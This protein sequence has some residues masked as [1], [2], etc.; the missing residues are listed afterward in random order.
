MKKKWF[1]AALAGTLLAVLLLNGCASAQTAKRQVADTGHRRQHKR[2]N[3]FDIAD[4]HKAPP[5][6]IRAK[7]TE[8]TKRSRSPCHKKAARTNG[9][10]GRV[11]LFILPAG[12]AHIRDAS[13]PT[14]GTVPQRQSCRIPDT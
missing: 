13:L 5:H 4:L 14:S 8:V 2:I 11:L 10:P 1:A 6:F 3:Q 12:C 9:L 7:T